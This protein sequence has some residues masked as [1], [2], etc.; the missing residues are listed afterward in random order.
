MKLSI[1]DRFAFGQLFPDRGNLVEQIMARD[2]ARKIEVTAEE[3][4]AINLRVNGD[5]TVWDDDKAKDVD[6]DFSDAEMQFLS[7]QVERMNRESLINRDNLSLCE[8]IMNSKSYPQ[9]Q[10]AKEDE[11]IN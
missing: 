4:A 10:E 7:Q 11:K 1:R 9:G 2:L 8:K 5:L 6:V 3:T